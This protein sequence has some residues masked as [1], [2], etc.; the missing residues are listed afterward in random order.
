MRLAGLQ[1][2][3]APSL[4]AAVSACRGAF[5]GLALFSALVNVLYLTGSFYM[6]Q[7]YDRVL[8]SRSVPTLI[9]LSILA[10]APLRWP[11]RP[12]LLSQPHSVAHGPIPR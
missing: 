6:L 10:A 4:M 7:V 9:A 3:P 1:T 8:P 12:R 11:G 2:K 5:M